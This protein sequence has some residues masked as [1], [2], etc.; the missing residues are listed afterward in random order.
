[1]KTFLSFCAALT[2]LAVGCGD[3]S[4]QKTQTTNSVSGGNS[5]T[6]PVDY[7]GALA[8]AKKSTEK[9]VDTIA[10]NQAIQMFEVQ[11][12]RFPKDLNELVEKKVIRV[13]P[14]APIGSKI[15][16]DA[17]SGTVKVVKQ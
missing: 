17:T 7:L 1:M 8:K 3:S 6:A 9:T 10:L 15:E 5:I 4:N 14:Q 2:F 12:G 16:Y 11:E 13:L